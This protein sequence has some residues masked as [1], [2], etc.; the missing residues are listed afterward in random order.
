MLPGVRS[1]DE[2]KTLTPGYHHT[3]GTSVSVSL[4]AGVVACLLE[5]SPALDPAGVKGTLVGTARRLD[6][7]RDRQGSGA[8]DA[9]AALGLAARDA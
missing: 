8:I 2:G 5:A 9:Q 3:D 1:R 4:A 6:G 7:P